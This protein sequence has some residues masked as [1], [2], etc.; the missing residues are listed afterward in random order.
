MNMQDLNSKGSLRD[1]FFNGTVGEFLKENIK[2]NASLSFVSAY[3]FVISA[4]CQ[5]PFI[6]TF[7]ISRKNFMKSIGENFLF[8]LFVF[9]ICNSR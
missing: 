7:L 2:V 8:S 3:F 4:L 1:N 5:I 6:F 9:N